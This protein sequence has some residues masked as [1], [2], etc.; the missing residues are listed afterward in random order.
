[1]TKPKHPPEQLDQPLSTASVLLRDVTQSDL[2][3][4]FQHQLDPAANHLAAFTAKDPAD[5]QAFN[6]HWHRILA[7]ETTTIKTVLFEEQ[8][9]G[10]VLTYQE[11]GRTEISY[12]IG[13]EHWGKGIAT[14]ALH[15]FL[16][17]VATRPLHARAAKDNIPSLRVLQKCG[18]TIIGEDKGYANARARE[19]EEF[20]LQLN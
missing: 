6:A 3:I 14:A 1:M 8:V 5:R 2:P 17:H 20:I 19:I 4:F 18:F 16:Q 7:D 11:S 9:V 10:H 12:W 13:K 15:Q